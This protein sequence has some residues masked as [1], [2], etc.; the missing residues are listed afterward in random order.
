MVGALYPVDIVSGKQRVRTG[1]ILR[2]LLSV[3]TIL[4][5]FPRNDCFHGEDEREA[6]S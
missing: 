2:G 3:P 1:S 5:L 4:E 6:A